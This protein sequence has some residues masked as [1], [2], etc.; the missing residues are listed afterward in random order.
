MVRYS[1]V[2]LLFVIASLVSAGC[3]GTGGAVDQ[4]PAGVTGTQG[5]EVAD[6]GY[7]LTSYYSLGKAVRGVP[8]LVVVYNGAKYLFSSEEN[9]SKFLR[10]A[11][12]YI[13]GYSSHCPVSLSKGKN[14]EGKPTIWRIHDEKLYFF[15]NEAAAREFDRDPEGTLKKATENAASILK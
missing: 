13:P 4:L 9:R 15:A 11:E 12:M 7:D 6:D 14:V 3:S 10:S 2:L 5:A 1:I 8:E